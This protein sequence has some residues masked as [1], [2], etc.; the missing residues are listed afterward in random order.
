MFLLLM[1]GLCG[2]CGCVCGGCG[3]VCVVVVVVCGGCGCVWWLWSLM[4][5]HSQA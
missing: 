2:G 1:C 4:T 3:C 5:P